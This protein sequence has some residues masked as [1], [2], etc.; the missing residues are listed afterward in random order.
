MEFPRGAVDEGPKA[1]RHFL[2]W[3]KL[4]IAQPDAASFSYP[5]TILRLFHIYSMLVSEFKSVLS[6]YKVISSRFCKHPP[7]RS[8]TTS[9][10]WRV[11]LR[12]T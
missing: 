9:Q 7:F 12:D 4:E 2:Y 10:T 11:R 6:Q 1:P 5:R 8:P 3:P